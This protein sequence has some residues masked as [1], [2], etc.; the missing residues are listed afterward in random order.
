MF[1]T[2]QTTH[3]SDDRIKNIAHTFP[4]ERKI[5]CKVIGFLW[6]DNVALVSFKK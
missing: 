2:L 5:D 4:K 3:L 6:C 1:P